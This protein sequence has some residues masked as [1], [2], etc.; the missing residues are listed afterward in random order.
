[1]RCPGQDP[2]YWTEDFVFEVPCPECGAAVEF[3]KDETFGRCRKC[4]HR[5]R[6]PGIDLRC[7]EWC[8]LAEKCLGFVPENALK[9]PDKRTALAGRL[10]QQLKERFALRPE[11][12]ALTLRSFH[13][14]RE[15]V[16]QEGG[17]PR[18]VL[19]AAL[20]Y[21]WVAS[22][23][24]A[25]AD[26]RKP[27][28]PEAGERDN[29][30]PDKPWDE[31]ARQILSE[32]GAD[33]GTIGRV[34]ECLRWGKRFEARPT[35]DGPSETP[36]GG[37]VEARIVADAVVLARMSK[38]LSSASAADDDQSRGAQD[39]LGRTAVEKGG[40][41]HEAASRLITAAAR[42]RAQAMLAAMS[43]KRTEQ[44]PTDS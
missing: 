11:P 9:Q 13:F 32:A 31:Q 35:G 37:S 28:G 8:A 23:E 43:P 34:V 25:K 24:R 42:E 4:G 15:L 30:E 29:A 18:V 44:E 7:A 39:S 14:A 2:R 20:L 33:E 41:L 17:E 40:V 10:L 22:L 19:A 16:A 1:M 6:N 36:T 38:E 3:F 5:F 21:E 27:Q 26:M 12:L